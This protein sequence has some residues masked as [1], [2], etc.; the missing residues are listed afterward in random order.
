MGL[1]HP[2]PDVPEM[3]MASDARALAEELGLASKHVFFNDGWVAYKDRENFLLEAD[4][5]V[6][7]HFDSA[8]TRF[9]FRTRALDYLWAGL[10]VVTTQGDSFAQLV[11]DEGLGASVPPNDPAALSNALLRLLEVPGRAQACRARV[12]LVRERFRWSVVLEPL[13][14]FCADPRRAPDLAAGWAPERSAPPSAGVT[15][16]APPS[17]TSADAQPAEEARV[18]TPEARGLAQLAKLHYRQGGLSQVL[19]R[20]I[21][22]ACRIAQGEDRQR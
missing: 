4:I 13:D 6:T 12:A 7:T 19:Q 15:P 22:K 16:A 3:Q 10:P 17:G 21:S 5:G 2:N 9:S 1:R 14:R 20:A 11:E 18:G 8:E